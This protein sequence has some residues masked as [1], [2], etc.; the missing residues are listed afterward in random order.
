MGLDLPDGSSFFG[1]SVEAWAS[2]LHFLV[3]VHSS[4]L[5]FERIW[6]PNLVAI[7]CTSKGSYSI[8]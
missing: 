3:F 7:P 6:A 4:T 2:S 1:F 8:P 5:E